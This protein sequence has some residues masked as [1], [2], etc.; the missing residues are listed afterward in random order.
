MLLAKHTGALISRRCPL[1]PSLYAFHR[2]ISQSTTARNN[3][4]ESTS[5]PEPTESDAATLF[6]NPTPAEASTTEVETSEPGVERYAN[7]KRRSYKWLYSDD[8]WQYALAKKGHTNWL[9]RRVPFPMNPAFQPRTPTPD[10][11]REEI[12]RVWKSDP[13]KNTPRMLAYRFKFSIHRIEAILKLKVL[14]KRMEEEGKV[15][16]QK[17]LTKNMENLLGVRQYEPSK[18]DAS[19]VGGSE[20]VTKTIPEV[21]SPL[22][23][24]IDEEEEY[25]AQ[26][27]ARDLQK[28]PLNS[29]SGAH[30]SLSGTEPFELVDSVALLKQEKTRDDHKVV[31]KNP[32]LINRRWDFMFTDINPNLPPKDRKILVR[33]TEGVLRHATPLERKDRIQKLWPKDAKIAYRV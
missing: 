23:R 1:A 26:D 14:E 21:G 19:L 8:G 25:S 29:S 13:T 30:Q 28:A 20:P 18:P 6:E 22:F 33:T 24:A 16:L 2:D 12:Y 31:E 32:V 15:A 3:P 7:P 17:D 5:S 9:G 4:P 10:A 11:M 27:A